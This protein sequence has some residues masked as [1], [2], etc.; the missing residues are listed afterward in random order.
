MPAPGSHPGFA[1]VVSDHSGELFSATLAS[2]TG[3]RSR[4]RYSFHTVGGAGPAQ[5]TAADA[6]GNV[7]GSVPRLPWPAPRIGWRPTRCYAPAIFGRFF[8]DPGDAAKVAPTESRPVRC[9]N[10]CPTSGISIEHL[11]APSRQC[12]EASAEHSSRCPPLPSRTADRRCRR[13]TESDHQTAPS[14]GRGIVCS[15]SSGAADSRLRPAR[16]SSSGS[17]LSP[18]LCPASVRMTIRWASSARA[19]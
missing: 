10:S 15:R 8:S 19:S 7:L 3:Q 2:A 17:P 6:A 5:T 18:S 12:G 4:A 13:P 11:T 9:G 1:T 16:A 14:R